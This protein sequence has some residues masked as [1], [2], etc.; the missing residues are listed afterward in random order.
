[1]RLDTI[2]GV[3]VLSLVSVVAEAQTPQ[4]GLWRVEAGTAEFH[5]SRGA[6]VAARVAR[7]WRNDLIRLDAGILAGNADDG[8]FAVDVGPELRLCPARCRVVP[9]LGVSMGVLREP[10][11]GTGGIS[12]A[13][14]GVEIAVGARNLLRVSLYRGKHGTGQLSAGRGP[15]VITFGYGR[16]FGAAR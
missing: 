14:G 10:R 1:M 13:G 6:M 12:R 16:R 7:T 2:V 3:F 15:H 4:R 8:F 9:F 11:F 5:V